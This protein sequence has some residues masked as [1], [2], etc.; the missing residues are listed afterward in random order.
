MQLLHLGQTDQVEVA[1]DGVLE[2]GRRHRE[3]QRLLPGCAVGPQPVDQP[4]GEGIAAAHA[5]HDVGDVVGR[6]V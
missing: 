6:V 4:A 2:A 1:E 3:V 5:V